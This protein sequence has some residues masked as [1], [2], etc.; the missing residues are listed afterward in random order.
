MLV[1]YLSAIGGE[2]LILENRVF[3]IPVIV[4]AISF[5]Y[6]FQSS[7]GQTDG[8]MSLDEMSG[9]TPELNNFTD[10]IPLLSQ[11]GQQAAGNNTGNNTV[12]SGQQAT[13]TA[14]SAIPVEIITTVITAGA[15]G[16]VGFLG[17]RKDKAVAVHQTKENAKLEIL[18]NTL[19][20]RSKYSESLR[21][22]R[23][24]YYGNLLS[25]L[26]GL[27][28]SDN[29]YT[30]DHFTKMV[31]QVRGWYYDKGGLV[32]SHNSQI[33]LKNLRNEMDTVRKYMI[34]KNMQQIEWDSIPNKDSLIGA[35]ELL[36]NILMQDIDIPL[37]IKNLMKE[38]QELKSD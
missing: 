24:A 6:G 22:I 14:T 18:K 9:L 8:T 25:T 30:Q 29:T 35:D 15:T 16:F 37:E 38:L 36:R 3:I 28:T 31:N 7:L 27:R 33:A 13:P 20:L 23:M 5:A 2:Y 11:S 1:L 17:G 26:K 32:L 34:E 10:Q 19:E 4:T 21:N 12:N